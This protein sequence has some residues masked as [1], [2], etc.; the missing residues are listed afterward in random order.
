M[1]SR[2]SEGANDLAAAV[3]AW[4]EAKSALAIDVAVAQLDDEAIAGEQVGPALWPLDD[5]DAP[6][7]VI[8]KP[9]FIKVFNILDPVKIDV[10]QRFPALVL[11]HQDE[12]GAVD[13]RTTTQAATDALRE[14]G[15]AGTEIPAEEDDVSLAEEPPEAFADVARLFFTGGR[16]FKVVSIGHASSIGRQ[17]ATPYSRGRLGIMRIALLSDV[18]SNLA[19]LDAVL[20]HAIGERYEA[21]WHMGD[22]VGYG[23]DPNAVVAR[24]IAEGARCVMGNHDAAAVG[25]IGIEAFNGPAAEAAQWTMSTIT[26]ASRAY[27]A[28]LPQMEEDGLFTRV[29]GTASDP[30]WEYLSTYEAASRHFAAVQTQFSVVG[31]THLPLV[32]RELDDGAVDA[33]TPNEG[34]LVELGEGRVCLNPGGVGQPRD[35]DPRSAYALLDTAEGSVTFHRVSYD[36]AHTQARMRECS[37]PPMLIER[38][39]RGR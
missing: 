5:Q 23:P 9:Q 2:R 25:T 29:H 26:D 1:C 14:T 30:I 34:D 24:M 37:L 38:L 33:S 31:H 17:V 12:R 39:A 6:L 20:A 21:V 7:G 36:I 16:E 4:E 35:G 13:G 19:A 18:H 10:E 22:L 8:P 28:A 11:V 3:A 32:V 27:L 15:L